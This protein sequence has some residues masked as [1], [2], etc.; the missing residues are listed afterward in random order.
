MITTHIAL[1]T[2][3]AIRQFRTRR[4]HAGQGSGGPGIG[5]GGGPAGRLA[6][7]RVLTS[8]VSNGSNASKARQ[9][10]ETPHE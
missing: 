4:A 8:V 7:G 3:S 10:L 5:G 2:S 1:E 9:R 6:G